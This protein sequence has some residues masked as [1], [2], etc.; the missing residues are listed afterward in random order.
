M[1]VLVLLA[2]LPEV[3][4]CCGLSYGFGGLFGHDTK[5]QASAATKKACT[6][7]A[8]KHLPS[9]EQ[10]SVCGDRECGCKFY[11]ATS[12]PMV[13]SRHIDVDLT[14]LFVLFD[15]GLSSS[16]EADRD[17]PLAQQIAELPATSSG[18]LSRCARLQSWQV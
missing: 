3:V 10:D 15:S 17:G 11:L 7:C 4:C 5:C 1:M 16:V 14:M 9:A 12:A 18:A 6:C 2:S 8:K 13:D